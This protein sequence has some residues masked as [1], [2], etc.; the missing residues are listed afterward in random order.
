MNRP[1]SR[2]KRSKVSL[3][4]SQ[5][6][7]S[8]MDL[9][10]DSSSLHVSVRSGSDSPANDAKSPPN[11]DETG[12][13]SD[14]TTD[15]LSS[16][17]IRKLRIRNGFNVDQYESLHKDKRGEPK[18]VVSEVSISPGR[19]TN[20]PIN[21]QSTNLSKSTKLHKSASTSSEVPDSSSESP[22]LVKNKALDVDLPPFE[23]SIIEG[24]SIMAFNTSSEMELF[25]V[26]LLE[27]YKSRV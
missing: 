20:S 8:D 24:F 4:R 5:S 25:F 2:S 22:K 23:E 11:I 19:G 17:E 7:R 3:V 18:S 9:S 13:L 6:C 26:R 21:D 27:E 1:K 16:V 14:S 15:V 12:T 10:D